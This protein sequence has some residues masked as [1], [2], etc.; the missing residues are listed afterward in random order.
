MD[1][2]THLSEQEVITDALSSNETDAQ[3][4]ER[5]KIES[6]KICI[7]EDLAKEKMVVTKESSRAVWRQY[8][9]LGSHIQGPNRYADGIRYRDP[10]KSPGTADHGCMR[11]TDH[12]QPTL[13][14]EKSDDYIPIHERKWKDII[15]SAYSH[16]YK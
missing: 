3:E 9:C 13:Q 12:E 1:V 6:N 4:L 16:K 8:R 11:D 2:D 15:P 5:V 7:R 10:K 14:L